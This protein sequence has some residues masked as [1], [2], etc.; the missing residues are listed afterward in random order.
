VTTPIRSDNSTYVRRLE[1]LLEASRLLNSTLELTELTEIVLRI[2]KD[3]VPVDRCTLFVIDPHRKTLRSFVAQGMAEAEISLP[4]GEGLAGTVASTG[5]VLDVPDVYQDARFEQRFDRQFGYRTKDVLCVPIVNRDG[6]PIGVLQLL[7]RR[8]ALTHTDREFL[9]SMCTYIGLAVHNAWSHHEILQSRNLEHDLRLVGDRLAHAE[10]LCELNELV[11]GIVHEMRNPLTIARGQCILLEDEH[12]SASPITERTD[13]I[14]ASIDRALKVAQNFLNFARTAG[15]DRR[16]TDINNLIRQTS[17]LLTYDFRQHDVTV[18]LDLKPVPFVIMDPA[19]IQQVL[20]NL[21]R[22]AQQVI[23]EGKKSGSVEVRSSQDSD[24]HVIRVE[25][26]DDGPGIPPDAR[27]KIFEPF[28]TTKPRG[29]GTGL[30]L[31][32]SRRI[33]EQHHGR[34]WFESRPANGTRFLIELPLSAGS[35]AVDSAVTAAQ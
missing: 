6:V 27:E 32:V 1:R 18:V 9:S 11:A 10:K 23:A 4:I 22:N 33:I 30:G 7:N 2:V 8:R 25:V 24:N 28:F 21:L 29:S 12:G 19:G 5:E 15:R 14:K 16:P 26:S 34:L 35:E 17:D 13:K 3:E 20:L 31:A